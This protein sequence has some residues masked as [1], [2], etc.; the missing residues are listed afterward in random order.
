MVVDRREGKGDYTLAG[1][2][3]FL[4]L[5]IHINIL[6]FVKLATHPRPAPPRF[7]SRHEKGRW[8]KEPRSSS[9]DEEIPEG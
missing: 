7:L 8:N 9:L 6:D 1:E 3:T 2:T 5:L 4:L